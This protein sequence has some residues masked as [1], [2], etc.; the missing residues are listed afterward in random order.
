MPEQ[1]QKAIFNW[2][3]GKDS[4][5]ALH[6]TLAEGRC[7]VT[8]LL[9]S[10]SRPF[11]RISMHGVR[12]DLLRRQAE[13]LG[14]PLHLMWMPEAPDMPEYESIVRE[15]LLPLKAAG[16]EVCIFGDIFLEDLRQYRIDKLS[17][18]GIEAVFPIWKIPTDRLVREFIELGYRAVL[19][20]VS[21]KV[22]DRGFAG[23]EIDAAFLRDLPADVD[24]CGENGE[25]HSFVFD[26]PIFANPVDFTRGEV[27]HRTYSHHARDAAPDTPPDG[28]WYCDL[29]PAVEVAR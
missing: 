17:E 3:G 10:V 4:T 5:M 14:F 18:L 25:F 22:L 2:S 21:E 8:C 7:E 11:E 19:S 20:C 13:S 29:V 26:G 6:K 12:V 23:R 16:N 15:T 24:P 9:T 27:V 28:F 1:K